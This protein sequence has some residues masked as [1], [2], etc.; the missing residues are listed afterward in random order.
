[1]GKRGL[2]GLLYLNFSIVLWRAAQ[3]AAEPDAL[4]EAITQFGDTAPNACATMREVE[5]P[6]GAI[7]LPP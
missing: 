6:V 5:T 3:A 4:K 2:D 1:M 7:R